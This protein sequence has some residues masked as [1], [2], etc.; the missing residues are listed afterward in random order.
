MDELNKTIDRVLARH[1]ITLQPSAASPTPSLIQA[2]GRNPLE[3]LDV[4]AAR[5]AM[6]SGDAYL[7]TLSENPL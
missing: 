2:H 4:S 3:L 7:L 5:R 6:L 1:G